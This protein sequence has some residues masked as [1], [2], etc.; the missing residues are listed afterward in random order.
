MKH[1]EQERSKRHNCDGRCYWST[2]MC[3]RVEICEETK[4]SERR[5]L[6][7]ANIVTYVLAAVTMLLVVYDIIKIFLF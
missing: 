4:K 6:I 2:G 1:T 7:V 5:A 3:P